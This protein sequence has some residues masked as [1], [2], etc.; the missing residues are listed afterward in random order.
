MPRPRRGGHGLT[1]HGRFAEFASAVEA[2]S[3]DLAR[4]VGQ[5]PRRAGRARAAVRR[6]VLS[7]L[8]YLLRGT[9]RATPFGLLAGVAPARIGLRAAFSAGTGHRGGRQ[10]GR[11]L[12]H[13]RDRAP[14]GGRGTAAPP[15]RRGQRP[16]SRTGRAPGDRA[17][18]QR[19]APAARRSAS[20]YARPGP[21]LR[22]PGGGT[23]PGP[24]SRPGREARRRLPRGSPR[25]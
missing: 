20:R 8:R 5:H 23:V 25:T 7:M 1:R 2:A 10:G 9:S 21:V 19:G 14:G 16:D 13:E 15:D 11:G 3:P 4:Q 6:A 18:G 12:A 24:G 17:T 22:G